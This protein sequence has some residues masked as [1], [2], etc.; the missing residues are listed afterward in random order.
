MRLKGKVIAVDIAN[1][2]KSSWQTLIPEAEETLEAVGVLNNQFVADYLKDAY[3]Q[4]KL[5]DLS[6][7]LAREVALPG[8]GS[9]GGFSGK[10]TDTETFYSFTS[11]TVPS[12]IYHY[13]FAT[14]KSTLFREP[15]IPFD[16]DQ[17]E[18]RQVFYP[19]KDGTEIPMFITAKKGLVLN[20]ENPTL[21]YGYGGFSIS[22]SPSFSS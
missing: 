22:L 7:T 4:V 2:E 19:S 14:D 11:Y 15:T 17:Y 5:F 1:P 16:P 8:I 21:L 9:A 6:G 10:R 20:G 12:R 3:T 18:T 13:D